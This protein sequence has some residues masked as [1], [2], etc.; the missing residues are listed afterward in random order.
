MKADYIEPEQL[1][2]LQAQISRREWLP[3][4]VSLETGLRVGD[5]I[6]IR[7]SDLE[8]QAVRY[9]AQ[10]T[11]KSGRAALSTERTRE[12]R[13]QARWGWCFPSPYK[14]GR[15]ITRQAVWARVKRAAARASI[16]PKGKSPHSARKNFAVDLAAKEGL[17][18]VK[19]QLQHE[20]LDITE[21]YAL[22][23]WTSGENAEKPLLRKDLGILLEKLLA[24]IK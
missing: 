8:D 24:L 4:A 3:F 6:K 2:K 23:D 22:A 7:T 5:V 19:E 18:A 21:L 15:H 12:L 17:Q 13:A 20:R 10:K 16:D 11:K 9:V 14:K 1:A